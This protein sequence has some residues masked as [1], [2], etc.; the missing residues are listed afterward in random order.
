MSPYP[1]V[2]APLSRLTRSA[3][4]LVTDVLAVVILVATLGRG[5]ILLE[6]PKQAMN[7]TQHFSPDFFKVLGFISQCWVADLIFR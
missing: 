5:F 2:G 1:I 7:Q 3:G 4:L 6:Q